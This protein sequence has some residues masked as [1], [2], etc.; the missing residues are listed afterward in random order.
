MSFAHN[1][2]LTATTAIAQVYYNKTAQKGATQSGM[3]QKLGGTIGLLAVSVGTNISM[4]Q[5]GFI[6][7]AVSVKKPPDEPNMNC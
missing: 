5:K 1:R 6:D 2:V 3:L 7:S 4:L